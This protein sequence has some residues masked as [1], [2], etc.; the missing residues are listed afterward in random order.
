MASLPGAVVGGLLIGLVEVLM[1]GYQPEFFPWL[2]TG[3]Y[4]VSGY[5][6]MVAI[7]LIRPQ[8]IFGSRS[9]ERV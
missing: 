7:L 8:G 2:G 9:G 6:V 1:A 5:V 4:I 3:F